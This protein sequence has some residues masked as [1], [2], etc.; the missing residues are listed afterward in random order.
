MYVRKRRRPVSEINVVPYIDVMLVLLIIFMVTAPL[1]TQG[2]KVDLPKAEAQPLEDDSKP[3]LIA[4]VDADGNYF[5]NIA[6][7]QEQAMTAADVA[8]LVAAHLRIEPETPVVVKGDG[9]VPYSNIVQLMVLLQR[10]GAPSVG[11]MT[12]PPEN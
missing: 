2:V 11:L 9:A 5:L 4:S 3:P 8:T 12:D 6:E 10:A 1:V 7:D